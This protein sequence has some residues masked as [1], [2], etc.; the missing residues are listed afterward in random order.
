MCYDD[1]DV[2]DE[3]WKRLGGLDNELRWES[4]F[5]QKRRLRHRYT[6]AEVSVI[7]V[8][9]EENDVGQK[10]GRQRRR[11]RGLV[12][13]SQGGSGLAEHDVVVGEDSKLRRGW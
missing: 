7:C 8:I 12:Y 4:A 13:I 2:L 6:K 9:S 3:A 5:R 11:G 1:L 10:E